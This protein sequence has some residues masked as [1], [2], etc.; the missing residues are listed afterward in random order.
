MYSLFSPVCDVCII[1]NHSQLCRTLNSWEI[2][3]VYWFSECGFMDEW[4]ERPLSLA[5]CIPWTSPPQN[6]IKG[7]CWQDSGESKVLGNCYFVIQ[8]WLY[9]LY[10]CACW[11]VTCLLPTKSQISLSCHLSPFYA[12]WKMERPSIRVFYPPFG[13]YRMVI[14]VVRGP[15]PPEAHSISLLC[16]LFAL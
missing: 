4:Y 14:S 5:F 10:L 15:S 9:A 2:G 12:Q 1:I 11:S 3:D 8:S 16:L 13:N 6:L 7:H